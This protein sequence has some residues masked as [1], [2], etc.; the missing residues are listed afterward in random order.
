MFRSILFKNVLLFLVILLVA[1]VPLATRYYQDSRDYEIQNLASKLEF[2]AERGAGWIDVQAVDRL[3]RAEDKETSAYRDVL[4]S[5]NRIKQ[6]FGVDNAILM[7][8]ESDGHYSYIAA[9][10]GGFDIG[11]PAQIHSLFPATY[12]ATN[13]TWLQGAMMHSQLFGGKVGDTEYDQFLQINVPLKVDGQVMAILMLNKFANPVARAV[14]AKTIRVVALS[15]AIVAVGLGLFSLVSARM[16]RLLKDLTAVAGEVA[17]GNLSVSVPRSR[18]RDEVGRLAL[19]FGTMLEGLRQRD[20]IRDTFGRYLTRE[21]V[22]EILESP[23]GLKLGGEAR[24]ITLLVT[25]LRGFTPIAARLSPREVL[26]LLNRYLERMVV[27]I[28]RH[29]GTIDEIQ[30]DG[31]LAF[32]GAPV[33]APDDSVRAVACALEMQLALGSFNSEQRARGAPELA[34]GIGIN[35]GEVIVGN[36]GSEQRAKYGAVGSAINMA[37]RIESYT[38][39]GQILLSPSTYEHVA[40]LVEVAGVVEV[41]LKG[42]DRLLALYEVT[43]LGGTYGLVLPA[44]DQEVFTAIEPPLPIACYPVDGKAVSPTA[45]VGRIE[46]LGTRAAEVVLAGPIAAHTNVKIVLDPAATPAL[47]GLYAKILPSVA[48]AVPA[49]GGR[50]TGGIVRIAFTSVPDESRAYLEQRRLRGAPPG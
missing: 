40:S 21:V 1:V 50:P 27:V 47:L 20:F 34:M 12:K 8:R 9:D 36:I 18:S 13:D 29:R 16:L 5:L 48:V 17:A 24:V 7:R 41:E 30:G 33:A 32:F 10:H 11:R 38:T 22:Q 37:Y 43:G 14:R 23:D 28:M 25:D 45:I 39:G 46:R 15:L 19:T 26:E 35:T 31:L 49:D 4:R 6:E 2:F 42:L 44:V 3:R